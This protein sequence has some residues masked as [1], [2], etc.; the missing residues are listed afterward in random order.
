MPTTLKE[1]RQK[2]PAYNDLS[3]QQLADA[4]YAKSYSDMPRADFDAKIGLTAAPSTVKAAP[5]RGTNW[6][7]VAVAVDGIGQALSNMVGGIKD[8][9]RTHTAR[10]GQPLTPGNIYAGE[11]DRLKR[12]GRFLGDLAGVVTS[13]PAALSHEYIAGPAADALS[14]V[15]PVYEGPTLSGVVEGFKTGKVA[16]RRQLSQAEARD[17]IKGDINTAIGAAMPGR[18]SVGF[19]G[20][21]IPQGVS[22]LGRGAAAAR[23]ATTP[24]VYAERVA[25]FERAGVEPSIAA[26]RGGGASK[27]ANAIADNPVA[28]I[29]VRGQ[30]QRQAAQAGVRAE[31]LAAAYGA[32]RGPQIAGEGVQAGVRRFARDRSAIPASTAAPAKQTSF[33]AKADRLYDEAFAP[34]ETAEGQAVARAQQDFETQAANLQQQRQA[35]MANDQAAYE[36]AVADRQQ[37]RLLGVPEGPEPVPPQAPPEVAP[38]PQRA[39]VTPTATISALRDMSSRVNGQQ[40]SNLITDG[41]VRSI[42]GALENDGANVRFNDLRQLRTWVRNAQRDPT[43][44][45]GIAQADLENIEAALT[46]DVYANAERLGGPEALSKLQRADSY[47]RAGSERIN[48]ALQAFDS[49]NSGEQAYSRIVQ[50]AGSNAT[51]DARKLVALKRS[52]SPDEWGDVAATT[53]SNLGKPTAGAANAAEEGAF[54]VNTFLTNYAKLSPIGRE[55]LFGSRG[56]GGA[57]AARLK[58]ELD[59][60]AK[61]AGYLKEVAKGANSSNTAVSAQG[62][63]TI[64]GLA[65][66][67]TT[68]PTG[69][70]LGG[71][72]GTG[73]ILT[74]PRFVRMLASIAR[75]QQT[76][77]QAVPG[78]VQRFNALTAEDRPRL[79][80]AIPTVAG[81]SSAVNQALDRR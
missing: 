11:V 26:V 60:L 2:Y 58:D 4:L 34:I 57:E 24:N 16:P 18:G 81:D 37:R 45:Q 70:A 73:E 71:A 39:A 64:A 68:L 69:L 42:L 48:R 20:P 31:E 56:G 3:D 14:K 22:N 21:Q 1:I 8:D 23:V 50:A 62:M 30:M 80:A 59:N 43:L 17:K 38:P 13:I 19:T 28:G 49:A 10:V 55:V 52:L 33:V 66:P 25:Q 27:A 9:Y 63:A 65:N 78:M 35:R 36:R 74:N 46:S 5:K 44:R 6:N 41:R 54:S 7:P 75:A 40:L 61:V 72:A 79:A 15:A 67:G 29:R 47:Y 76:N 32:N 53:L 51:A 12:T 77:P